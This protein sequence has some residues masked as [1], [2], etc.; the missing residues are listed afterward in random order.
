[1]MNTTAPQTRG[2]LR[3][4]F[5]FLGRTI[6][7][8]RKTMHLIVLLLIFVPVIIAMFSDVEPLKQRTT[9]VL[10]LKGNIVE[11][12]TGHPSD[13][14]SAA[15]SGEDIDEVQLRDIRTA[16][17][18]AATDPHIVQ[19]LLRTENLLGAGLSTLREVGRE[20]EAF[21]KSGKPITAYSYWY[22]Q[23]GLYLA[24]HADKI[25][26]HPGGVAM[27]EGLGRN[28][29]YYKSLLDKLGVDV[30]VFRVGEFKSAVEPYLRDGPSAEA[31]EMDGYWLGDL[32]NILL[33][34]MA[35]LR[36][37]TPEQLKTLIEELGTRAQAAKGDMAQ[38]A[39]DEGLVDQLVTPDELKSM[40]LVKGALDEDEDLRTVGVVEYAE[41][42]Q[43]AAEQGKPAVGIIVAEG[44]II[45]GHQPPGT[46]GGDS[47]ADLVRKAREDKDVK[48]LVL[49]VDSPGGSGFASEIIR[50]ELELTRQAG[51]PVIVSMGDVAASGGY[52]ISMTS[53]AIYA[54]PA[55]ITGSIG[56]YAIVP[57]AARGLDKI[58]VHADG[59]TTT[60]LAGSFDVAKPLDPRLAEVIDAGIQHGYRDFIGK[61]AEHRKKTPD[62]ID[63]IGRGRVWSA[64]QAKERGLVDQLGSFDDAIAAAAKAAKLAAGYEIKY[65]EEELGA[66]DRF[67][68]NLG[69][70]S[71]V[72]AIGL[73]TRKGI[74]QSLLQLLEERGAARDLRLLLEGRS[75]NPLALYSY[76][77]CEL[78]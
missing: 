62:E 39:L 49:R 48:A 33:A 7:L 57:S 26:L 74:P 8:L 54:D 3:R 32:W 40:L 5:G 44:G 6:D 77:F 67:L 1:M 76:C 50:R 4:V 41:R 64:G 51:K 59:T 19:V 65:V 16:L 66:F 45:D 13:R 12:Y 72:Q 2:P 75:R 30:S 9:L 43:E 46:I 78:R 71:A 52:W 63:A 58:G 56:I 53:D 37:R 38:L 25:W 73:G 42:Q 20:I 61:V 14:L 35:R 23:R 68:A 36:Q 29:T 27:L 28:R 24:A 70:S 60:W 34:D 17:R 10:N 47:T 22:D 69:A 18:A 15:L 21:K 31:R 11:Q 55:T